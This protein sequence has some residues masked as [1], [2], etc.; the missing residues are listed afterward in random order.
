MRCDLRIPECSH[1]LT[2]PLFPK[3]S[4]G[5]FHFFGSEI[6]FDFQKTLIKMPVPLRA[7]IIIF[8]PVH[9]LKA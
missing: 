4:R 9:Q 8:E 5:D 7:V 2:V 1:H 6:L 3:I